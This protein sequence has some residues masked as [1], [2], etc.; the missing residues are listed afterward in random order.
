MEEVMALYHSKFKREAKKLKPEVMAVVVYAFLQKVQAY[1]EKTIDA[2]WNDLK[3]KRGKD[4]ERLEKLW[5]WV[6]YHRFNRIALEEIK[7]GTLDDWFK[8]LLE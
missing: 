4:P 2:K 5:N 7:D 3:K 6:Q 1:S 8:T